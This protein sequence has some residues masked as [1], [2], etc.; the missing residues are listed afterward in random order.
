MKIFKA[1]LLLNYIEIGFVLDSTTLP[2]FSKTMPN[3]LNIKFSYFQPRGVMLDKNFIITISKEI[4][5]KVINLYNAK[6]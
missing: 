6:E 3:V 2:L 1:L 5:I 4:K